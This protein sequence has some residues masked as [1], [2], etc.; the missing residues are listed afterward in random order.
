[1]NSGN[2]VE[3]RGQVKLRYS[4]DDR[5]KMFDISRVTISSVED[6][7]K[8]ISIIEAKM[9]QVKKILS[10]AAY[11][12]TVLEGQLNRP[13]SKTLS[14]PVDKPIPV[15][16]GAEFTAPDEIDSVDLKAVEASRLEQMKGNGGPT[17]VEEKVENVVAVVEDKVEEPK[18]ETAAK[19]IKK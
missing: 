16:V 2:E 11:R 5:G 10:D 1:M 3:Q 17:I 19:K 6:A 7:L 9:P 12:V 8:F 15:A 18:K 13:A 14:L 4:T